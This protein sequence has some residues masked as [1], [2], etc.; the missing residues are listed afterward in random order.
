MQF[1]QKLKKP[2]FLTQIKNTAKQIKHSISVKLPLRLSYGST[3]LIHM[4]LSHIKIILIM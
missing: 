3:T 4:T 1:S 2:E